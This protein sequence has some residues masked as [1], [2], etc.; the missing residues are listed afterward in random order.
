MDGESYQ[1]RMNEIFIDFLSHKLENLK[2]SLQF[3][4]DYTVFEYMNKSRFF[5]NN[6]IENL[7]KFSK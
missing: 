2:N 4:R 6:S 3:L 7:L 5:D 1:K